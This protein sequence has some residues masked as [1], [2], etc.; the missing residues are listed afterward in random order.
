M[1]RLGL[2]KSRHA[3]VCYLV[4]LRLLKEGDRPVV[5]PTTQGA[6]K[7]FFASLPQA[8]LTIVI[9]STANRS[10][11]TLDVEHLKLCNF[12]MFYPP[13]RCTYPLTAELMICC[14]ILRYRWQFSCPIYCR[15]A[16]LSS[17][18][19]LIFW[20]LC[21]LSLHSRCYRLFSVRLSHIS[22]GK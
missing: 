19:L 1:V 17:L 11:I 12:F 16:Q 5:F 15:L 14:Y 10:N 21:V 4:A 3:Q 6:D 8:H 18:C 9:S 2:F 7:H 13:N 20:L 22:S